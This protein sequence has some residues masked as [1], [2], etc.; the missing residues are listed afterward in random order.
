MATTDANGALHDPRGR[1]GIKPIPMP[2]VTLTSRPRPEPIP[3]LRG[4]LDPGAAGLPPSRPVDLEPFDGGE[5]VASVHAGDLSRKVVSA[6]EYMNLRAWHTWAELRARQTG[7]DDPAAAEHYDDFAKGLEHGTI[8]L[9][10]G[11]AEVARSY[12]VPRTLW[13]MGSHP[14]SVDFGVARRLLTFK[15]TSKTSRAEWASQADDA[16]SESARR[17]FLAAGTI[18]SGL[19]DWWGLRADP[20]ATVGVAL[21]GAPQV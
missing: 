19:D 11:T 21:A 4:G 1:Y 12:V 16:P 8:A 17:G 7:L 9:M 2:D 20:D 15:R 18:L 3:Y 6:A 13:S 14:R 10:S 5:L